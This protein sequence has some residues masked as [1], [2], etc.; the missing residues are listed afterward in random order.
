MLLNARRLDHVQ[1]ILVGI[2][3]VTER[4]EVERKL[5]EGEAH[6]STLA[7]AIPQLAWTATPDGR[8]DWYNNRCTNTLA[9]RLSR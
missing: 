8:S 5:Q 3:D 6:F 9:R 2:R 7:N 1:L 4:M